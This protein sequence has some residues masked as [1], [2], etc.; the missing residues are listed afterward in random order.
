LFYPVHSQVLLRKVR[1]LFNK[2]HHVKKRFL[3]VPAAL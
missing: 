1:P 2:I 3:A